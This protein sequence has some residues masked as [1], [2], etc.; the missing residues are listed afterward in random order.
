MPDL[1]S[2]HR[3]FAIRGAIGAP[4]RTEL[5][6]V[7]DLSVDVEREK[8]KVFTTGLQ[9]VARGMRSGPL[10]VSGELTIVIDAEGGNFQL[11]W[12]QMHRNNE[13]WSIIGMRKGQFEQI[14][15][16]ILDM[17]IQ[18]ISDS[19]S[20]EDGESTLTISFEAIDYRGQD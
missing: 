1:V 18:S 15:Y 19:H 10:Q 20:A 2:K 16:E 7:T 11:P 6:R 17:E 9:Q 4:S 5:E 13:I 12:Y 14:D 3:I 8:T